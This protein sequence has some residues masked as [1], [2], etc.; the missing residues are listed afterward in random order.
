MKLI[1]FYISINFILASIQ[2]LF[3]ALVSK[4]EIEAIINSIIIYIIWTLVSIIVIFYEIKINK[5]DFRKE[6]NFKF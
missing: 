2:V 1:T 3:S 5:T 4:T 6:I